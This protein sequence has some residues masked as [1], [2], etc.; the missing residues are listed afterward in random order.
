MSLKLYI[1]N[2]T[3]R[4]IYD[5][6][7]HLIDFTSKHIFKDQNDFLEKFLFKYYK[8]ETS[9]F[10]ESNSIH[11]SIDSHNIN[12]YQRNLGSLD[13]MFYKRFGIEFIEVK[14]YNTSI[15]SDSVFI[16]SQH[17]KTFVPNGI[18]TSNISE[19]KTLVKTI[20]LKECCFL[21]GLWD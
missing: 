4:F 10:N 12:I 2:T 14:H 5:F 17:M 15:A 6:T 16:Y 9:F 13:I 7:D 21:N 1:K 18:L 3:D 11:M 20:T 8:N 19:Y